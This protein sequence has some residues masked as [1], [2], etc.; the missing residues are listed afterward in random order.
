MC[1]KGMFGASLDMFERLRSRGAA[2]EV[3]V[4]LARESS[5]REEGRLEHMYAEIASEQL[6]T[7][8]AEERAR[9]LEKS[10]QGYAAELSTALQVTDAACREQR[11]LL[12]SDNFVTWEIWTQSFEVPNA[13]NNREHRANRPKHPQTLPI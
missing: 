10:G 7:Q 6:R 1:L 2:R 5:V 3:K 13:L 12:E 8:H 11:R 9:W 4:A